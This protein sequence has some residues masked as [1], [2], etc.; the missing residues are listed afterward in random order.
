M[1]DTPLWVL[2]FKKKVR[3]LKKIAGDKDWYEF[4]QPVLTR[5][6]KTGRGNCVAWAKLMKEIA[7]A[8]DLIVIIYVIIEDQYERE[9]GEFPHKI[10]ILIDKDNVVWY[11]S[12]RSIFRFKKIRSVLTDQTIKT[13]VREISRKNGKD[14]GYKRGVRVRMMWRARSMV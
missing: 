13:A 6:K 10:C 1:Q 7:L 8:S 11:Q 3:E 5:L 14:I 4:S 12:N 2:E 9:S